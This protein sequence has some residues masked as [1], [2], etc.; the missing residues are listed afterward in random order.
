MFFT[1]NNY[2]YTHY[3]HCLINTISTI[4]L[5]LINLLLLVH[6]C[7]ILVTDESVSLLEL[8]CT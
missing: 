8:D 5:H 4:Y 2:I 7:L 1:V 3:K 6:L